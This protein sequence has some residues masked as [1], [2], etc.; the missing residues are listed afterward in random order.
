MISF[1]VGL[2]YER[3]GEH[4]LTPTWL[5]VLW[6][7]MTDSDISLRRAGPDE[8]EAIVAMAAAAL[9]WRAG[10]PNAELFR[11]KHVTNP[12]GAS[13]MWV[14][15]SG[16]RLAGFRA[17]MRWEL[18]D[19]TGRRFRAVRAVDTATHPDFQ[20]R[21]I[22][23]KLTMHGVQ[24][25]RLEGVDFVFNTPNDQ[26]RPGYLKM[27]WIDVGRLPVAFRPTSFGAL[28]RVAR[29]RTA[30]EKWSEE[31]PVG[32]PALDVLGNDAIAGLLDSR[33]A[34]AG[35][36]TPLSA[37]YLQWRYGL[38]PLHYR[39]WAPDAVEDGVVVFRVRRRG[40]ARECSV[41]SVLS[42]GGGARRALQ[43]L[44]GLGKAVDADYL[45]N[46][47]RTPLRGFI[48]MPGQGPRLTAR[49]VATSPP[50][51]LRGWD[52]SLGDIELF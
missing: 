17:L 47:S 40:S 8:V 49:E 44:H 50:A 1:P 27:G 41:G 26:S 34:P 46:M 15:E 37:D 2:A 28:V 22:F 6:R 16:D 7:L 13:P 30:A 11:W 10:E 23:S 29:A 24:E 4:R 36:A 52:M 21:G 31:S 18:M 3:D 12:F 14:A 42:P 35:L 43:L 20:R 48:P 5:T 25:M 51:S 9:G 33:P 38:E 19:A 32:V 39:A 45:L